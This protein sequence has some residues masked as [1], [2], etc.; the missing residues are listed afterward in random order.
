MSDI[1]NQEIAHQIITA[2]LMGNNDMDYT[3]ALAA[4]LNEESAY[5]NV[6]SEEGECQL[7]E[8]TFTEKD[9]EQSTCPIM[10]IPFEVGDKIT[11]LPC[12]HIFDPDGIRKWLK[13]EKAECPVCRYKMKSKEIKNESKSATAE[14]NN[15]IIT[16]RNSFF[17]NLRRVNNLPVPQIY[18]SNIPHP[19]GPSSARIA[20][21]VHE[22]DDAN[23]LM[24]AIMTTISQ[25][26]GRSARME[27]ITRNYNINPF[28]NIIVSNYVH[29]DASSDAMD[30]L[31]DD[32]S[33]D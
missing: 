18:S 20:N 16:G 2:L 25:R 29:S 12:G 19:F 14:E 31:D 22:E 11:Q 28:T 21:I 9:E 8:R 15:E 24:R 1:R 5:K 7:L 30:N 6:L 17:N 33:L 3:R 27:S 26:Q 13:D 23:D 32:N 10:H 4:S